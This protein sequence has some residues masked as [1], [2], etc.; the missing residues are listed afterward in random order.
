MPTATTDYAK[1]A[2]DET[3]KAVRQGQQAIVE[4]VKAW[5]TAVEKAMPDTPTLPVLPYSDE[6]P[7]PKEIVKTSFEFAGQ[8]LKVQREFAESI[9]DAAA[10]VLGKSGGNGKSSAKA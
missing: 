10:P 8:L 6:L 1:T 4:A 2:Q 5:V 7:N 9:L 3:L